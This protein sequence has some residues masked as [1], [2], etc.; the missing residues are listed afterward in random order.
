MK[1][2]FAL[3]FIYFAEFY[4]RQNVQP[5]HFGNEKKNY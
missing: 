4:L 5:H 3:F 1:I 2:I